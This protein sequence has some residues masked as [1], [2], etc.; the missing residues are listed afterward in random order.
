[1]TGL[2]VDNHNHTKRFSKD[3]RQTL[4]ELVEAGIKNGLL[5][6]TLSDHYDK[7][8]IGSDFV[9]NVSAYGDTPYEGEWIF[10]FKE[11]RQVIKEMQDKL[12]LS[13]TPFKLFTGVEIG[14][15]PEQNPEIWNY[16]KTQAFDS[17]IL[18]IHLLNGY[19]IYYNPKPYQN[20]PKDAFR[21]YLEVIIEMLEA[22]LDFD[23]VGHYDYVTRYAPGPYQHLK[24]RDFSDHFDTIFR[25]IRDQGKALELNTRTRYRSLDKTGVDNGLQ[26]MDVYK[27]F[28][29]LGGEFVAL[30][31]DSHE[32]QNAGRFFQESCAFLLQSG[33]KYVTHFEN[34]RAVNTKLEL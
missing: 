15:V 13:S 16:L 7:D 34:R 9:P 19:D 26:D 28:A 5:G 12:R 25:L 29:E 22:N 32:D 20:G 24:Y 11:Y 23:I 31:S 17:I 1:M 4:E 21:Q 33:V 27:R 3:A 30:S 18:S 10:D 14:Y 8:M 2:Y 6:L